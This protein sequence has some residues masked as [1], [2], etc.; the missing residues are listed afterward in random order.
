M[1]LVAFEFPGA[2]GNVVLNFNGER[3]IKFII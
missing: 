2:H 3:E 1:C